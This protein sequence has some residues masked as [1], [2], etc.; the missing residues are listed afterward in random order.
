M[1]KSLIEFGI[2]IKLIRLIK[3]CLNETCSRVQAGKHL[4]DMFPINN[5]L[6]Q[7]DA[8]LPLL[9]NNAVEYTIRKVQIHQDGLKLNSAL[10]LLVYAGEDYI[11]D[12]RVQNTGTSVFA[13][14]ENGLEVN[15]VN[16]ST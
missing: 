15:V 9:F 16:L 3:M 13:S 2:P 5:G 6:K 8:L 10:Q 14:K 1:Y 7:G 11:M 12:G 4:S